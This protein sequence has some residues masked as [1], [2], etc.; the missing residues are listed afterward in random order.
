MVLSDSAP[1]PGDRIPIP[2]VSGIVPMVLTNLL[3]DWKQA[4]TEGT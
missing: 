1:E 2:P 3:N 4:I